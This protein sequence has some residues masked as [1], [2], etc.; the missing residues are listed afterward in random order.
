MSGRTGA[1]MEAFLSPSR[2]LI[3]KRREESKRKRFK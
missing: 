3:D 1:L 2:G